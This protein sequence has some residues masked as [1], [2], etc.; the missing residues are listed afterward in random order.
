VGLKENV[1]MGR[2]IPA[3]TG[4]NVYF[5][6]PEEEELVLDEV[7]EDLLGAF[8]LSGTLIDDNTDDE[9]LAAIAAAAAESSATPT[10][11]VLPEDSSD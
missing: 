3:G 10:P 1:I 4:Y 9:V 6:E 5:K 7:E 11:S 2:L 8:D